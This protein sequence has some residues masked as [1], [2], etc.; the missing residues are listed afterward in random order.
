MTS[1]QYIVVV[2]CGRLGSLLANRLS[3]V[4]A[5]VVVI[6]RDETAF[7]HLS[8]EFSGF[9][10]LGNATEVEVLRRAKIEQADCVLAVTRRDNI[11]LMVAQV[12]K[13]I[14][15]VP[16]VIARVFNPQRVAVYKEFGIDTICTTSLA[17]EAF[18]ARLAS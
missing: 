8:S 18:L 6:D 16:Q 1:N 14:Y 13:V 3:A 7:R 11:N 15:K 10:V 4:G 9:Q 17:G 5:S 2:G 12:A